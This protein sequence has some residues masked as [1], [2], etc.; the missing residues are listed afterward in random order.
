MFFVSFDKSHFGDL[1]KKTEGSVSYGAKFKK[2]AFFWG[3]F[4]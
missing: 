2:Y 1:W 4:M 3:I